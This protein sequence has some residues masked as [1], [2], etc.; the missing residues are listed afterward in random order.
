MLS[1]FGHMERI[2]Q[3]LMAIRVLTVDTSEGRVWGRP[4][5]GLMDSVN[6]KGGLG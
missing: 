4:R 3:Y 2:D 6:S 5:L 1:W